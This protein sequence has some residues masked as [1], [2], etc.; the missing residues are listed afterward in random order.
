MSKISFRISERAA[1][2]LIRQSAFSGGSG[3]MY[4]HLSTDS[5]NQSWY[6][7]QISSGNHDGIPIARKGGVTLYASSDQIPLLNDLNL[8]YYEDISGGGFLITAPPGSEGCSCG[9]G[10]RM[11]E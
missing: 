1:A 9:S 7:I 8:D 10:F 5:Y 11:F 4:L 3:A 2:E 6:H